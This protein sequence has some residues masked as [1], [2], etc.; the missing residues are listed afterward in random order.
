MRILNYL[1]NILFLLVIFS[2]NGYA[3]DVMNQFKEL[4]QNVTR[5]QIELT[6]DI[7]EQYWEL[8]KSL[9]NGNPEKLIKQLNDLRGGWA[10]MFQAETW[11]S[12]KLSNE[13]G[14]VVK[15]SEFSRLESGYIYKMAKSLGLKKGSQNYIDYVESK[16]INKPKPLINAVRII[17]AS[18][19]NSVLILDDGWKMHVNA[20]TITSVLNNIEVSEGIYIRLFDKEWRQ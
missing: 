10:G 16:I 20:D 19:D 12:A 13:Q 15:T 8:L 4:H 1:K 11:K 6:K 2:P 9:S 3:N 18:V 7:H 5:G 14:R 17:E